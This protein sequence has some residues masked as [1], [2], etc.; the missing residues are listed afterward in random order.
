MCDQLAHFQISAHS[1]MSDATNSAV[2][3]KKKLQ[4]TKIHSVRMV[5]ADA[6]MKDPGWFQ[7]AFE[8]HASMTDCHA[9]TDASGVGALALLE[10]QFGSLACPTW[11]DAMKAGLNLC[12]SHHVRSLFLFPVERIVQSCSTQYYAQG[13]RAGQER[14]RGHPYVL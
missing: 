12:I 2:W 13:N 7:H 5:A 14:A 4:S 10:K 1:F 9:V 11:R 6:S 3:K 8:E